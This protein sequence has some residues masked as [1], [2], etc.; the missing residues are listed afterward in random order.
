MQHG[1]NVGREADPARPEARAT[2][3]AEA[4]AVARA[5]FG[6]RAGLEEGPR[7]HSGPATI[8]EWVALNQKIEY[9]YA[10]IPYHAECGGAGSSCRTTGSASRDWG[11]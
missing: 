6:C 3:G 9:E 5:F 2:S 7:P 1:R 4:D 8:K 11:H 10:F